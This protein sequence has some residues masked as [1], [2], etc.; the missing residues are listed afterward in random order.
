MD[1]IEKRVKK[2]EEEIAYM[3]KVW[4]ESSLMITN[5]TM[6]GAINA[7]ALIDI[8]DKKGIITKEEVHEKVQGDIEKFY[9]QKEKGDDINETYS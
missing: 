8:L 9:R 1:G 2:L 5:L 7:A 4:K 6:K 3:R